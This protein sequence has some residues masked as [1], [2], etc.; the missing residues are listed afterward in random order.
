LTPALPFPLDRGEV[1]LLNQG[2]HRFGHV[3]LLFALPGGLCVGCYLP[4]GLL[5]TWLNPAGRSSAPL[6]LTVKS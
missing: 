2:M 1:V 3:W 5:S 4:L 6:W